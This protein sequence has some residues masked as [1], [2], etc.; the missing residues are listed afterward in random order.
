[1]DP[2]QT[3]SGSSSRLAMILA[4]TIISWLAVVGCLSAYAFGSPTLYARANVLLCIPIALPALLLG[5]Y[6]SAAIS[7]A[8]GVIGLWQWRKLTR[9]RKCANMLVKEK[10][11][12]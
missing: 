3:M 6:S 8:F 11:G 4:I 2:T 9:R 10:E 5:A 12:P 7:V 1:M